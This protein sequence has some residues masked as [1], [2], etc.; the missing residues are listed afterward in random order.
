[1]GEEALEEGPCLLGQWDRSCLQLM[2]SDYLWS[3]RR[4]RTKKS[5]ECAL[6][7][8]IAGI[9][10]S[11]DHC[12][13]DRWESFS[14]RVLRLLSRAQRPRRL[15]RGSW[16]CFAV[17]LL[18]WRCI[19]R[20]GIRVLGLIVKVQGPRRGRR[21]STRAVGCGGRG[22]ARSGLRT[23]MSFWFTDAAWV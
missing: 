8:P 15:W 18:S 16:G 22:L 19:A 7:I 11:F 9:Q 23:R 14:E 21:L 4:P 5:V 13:I 2:F 10:N 1:M 20:C 17:G 3:I 6:D 12:S